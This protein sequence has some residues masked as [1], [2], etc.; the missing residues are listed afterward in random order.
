MIGTEENG[1]LVGTF[2]GFRKINPL[3]KQF[4]ARFKAAGKTIRVNV[5]YRQQA[6]IQKEHPVG[7]QVA[8]GYYGGH[9]HIE[10]RSIQPDIFLKTPVIS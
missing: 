6:F 7:S 8:L 2:V 3:S 5:D 10:S 1:V 9:W 4:T